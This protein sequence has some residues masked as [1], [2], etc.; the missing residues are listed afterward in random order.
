MNILDSCGLVRYVS[1]LPF[2][3]PKP[4]P[5]NRMPRKQLSYHRTE[6][7]VPLQDVPLTRANNVPI[8]YPTPLT[9]R[10]VIHLLLCNINLLLNQF[11]KEKSLTYLFSCKCIHRT[12]DVWPYKV[13]RHTPLSASHTFRVLSV[14]PLIIVLPDICDDQTPPVC[15]T[16][17]RRHCNFNY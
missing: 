17:V 6:H 13:C 9:L 7:N 12:V 14:L 10:H 15:P 3:D 2:P 1:I 8:Q 4:S 16:N 11:V 5:C